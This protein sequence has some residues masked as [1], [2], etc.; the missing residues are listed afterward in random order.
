MPDV[1]D[2]EPGKNGLVTF[3]VILR[4]AAPWSYPL[5]VWACTFVQMPDGPVAMHSAHT[6]RHFTRLPT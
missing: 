2:D 3:G 5:A 4:L 1:E 6:A